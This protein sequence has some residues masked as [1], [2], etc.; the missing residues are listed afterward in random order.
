MVKVK[1]PKQVKYI[2]RVIV[3]TAAAATPVC[4]YECEQMYLEP[5]IIMIITR[6]TDNGN[7]Q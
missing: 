1:I 4:L 6:K 7:N 5:K 2:R 3:N